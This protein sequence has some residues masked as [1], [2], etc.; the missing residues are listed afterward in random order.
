MTA[1]T[2]CAVLLGTAVRAEAY[3]SW[4]FIDD[5]E[6]SASQWYRDRGGRYV[7]CPVYRTCDPAEVSDYGGYARSGTHYARIMNTSGYA[8]TWV[9]LGRNVRVAAGS[10]YCTLSVYIRV[11]YAGT[12]PATLNVEVINT[13]AWT[14]AALKTYQR[15]DPSYFTS[16]RLYTVS[17][18]PGPRDVT[19]RLV[20]VGQSGVLELYADDVDIHCRVP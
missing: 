11:A 6:S 5:F 14:Y 4:A 1:L 20:A 2:V 17:W 12:T 16:Y 15:T 7:K 8:D 18:Y 13:A 9:S 3:T 10:E 19:V